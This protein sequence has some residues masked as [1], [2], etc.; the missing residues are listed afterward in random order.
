MERYRP[1]RILVAKASSNARWSAP[2][3]AAIVWKVDFNANDETALNRLFI[4]EQSMN[5]NLFDWHLQLIYI[6]IYILEKLINCV[7]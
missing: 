7:S 2:A 6:Y 1:I 5:S 4:F 3:A